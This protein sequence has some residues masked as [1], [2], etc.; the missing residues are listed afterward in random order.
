MKDLIDHQTFK[1]EVV[2]QNHKDTHM[3]IFIVPPE[4]S[5]GDNNPHLRELAEQ[6]GQQVTQPPIGSARRHE[7]VYLLTTYNKNIS[8]FLL[9]EKLYLYNLMIDQK[10]MSCS[11]QH[12]DKLFVGTFCD[13]I[14]MFYWDQK[15]AKLVEGCYFRTHESIISLVILTPSL[16]ICGQSN[17]YVDT[18][19]L[20]CKNKRKT[21]LEYSM[22]NIASKFCSK[23][24]YINCMTVCTRAAGMEDLPEG[25]FDLA[26]ACENGLFFGVVSESGE[27]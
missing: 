1:T 27:F 13:T 15:T 18:I 14:Y 3:N 9:Y 4:L 25:A 11:R 12:R 6:T 7:E 8:V 24:G 17:G 21:G 16:I 2:C 5:S 26:L 22:D 10:E 20:E 19:K 23:L